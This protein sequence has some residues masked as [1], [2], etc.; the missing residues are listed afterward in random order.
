MNLDEII[1]QVARDVDDTPE[2]GDVIAWVNRAL[3]DLT[4]I[5]NKEK[6]VTLSSDQL[7]ADCFELI[8]V[9]VNGMP[10]YRLSM[11]DMQSEGYKLW[12]NTIT[13]QNLTGPIKLFYYQNLPKVKYLNDV[14][15]IEE[16]YHDLF[17]YYAIGHLQFKE[18]DYEDRSDIMQKYYA[19]KEEYRNRNQTEKNKGKR[20][21]VSEK[22]S[23]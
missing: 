4:P 21:V 11:N 8:H 1:K 14:P 18:E 2:N 16:A 23:W 15:Q 13:L 9:L 20:R 10:A 12:G 6:E 7:P 22:V 3:A 17:V 5:A 19:R